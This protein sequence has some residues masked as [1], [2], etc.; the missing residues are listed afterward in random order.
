MDLS[1]ATFVVVDT[2]TTGTRPGHNRVIE[3]GAVKIADGQI[4]DTYQQLINPGTSIPYQITRLT[5]IS[6]AMVYSEPA[7]GSILD[8][9]VEF[10]GDGVFVAH[11]ARFDKRFINAA[12]RR[13]GRPPMRNKTLCTARLAR[14]LL[15]GLKSKGL[16]SLADFYSIRIV[17][18]HRAFDDAEATGHI[19]IRLLDKIRIQVESPSLADVLA[20][21][22]RPYKSARPQPS[23]IKKIKNEILVDLPSRSGVYF[24]YDGSGEVVYVGKAKNLKSRVRSYFNAIEA[25]PPKTREL[26]RVVRNV[27]WMETGNELNALLQESKLIKQLQPRFNRA[28]KRYGRKPF[29]KLDTSHGCPTIE[30]TYQ[31]VDDGAEYY[32]PVQGGRYARF[33]VDLINQVYQLRE[34]DETT[35]AQGKP[36]MYYEIGRCIGPCTGEVKVEYAEEVDR[37]R[38]FLRG[39]DES[40]LDRLQLRMEDAASRLDFEDAKLYRDWIVRLQTLF[41]RQRQIASNV[42]DHNSVVVVLDDN[43]RVAHLFF[44]RFGRLTRAFAIDGSDFERDRNA[45]ISIIRKTFDRH[46]VPPSRYQKSDVDEVRILANWMFVNRE[47]V[48]SVPWDRNLDPDQFAELVM[49]SA[50]RAILSGSERAPDQLSIKP[51]E[52]VQ[53]GRI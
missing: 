48:S 24:M 32:G 40:V 18:R 28:L 36:C 6:N 16:T 12:L 43:R 42:V 27:T 33:L 34:C 20:M 53:D 25:H 30:S 31:V 11:N 49:D 14:R 17:N 4:I 41:V 52:E 51:T 19:L 7:I 8:S 13:T 15:S 9:F 38:A 22:M 50:R 45:V 29:I 35:F 3:I 37:V 39:E 5:G 10:L 1:D 44:V 46:L 26:T 47:T 23:H 21:Q 2:E